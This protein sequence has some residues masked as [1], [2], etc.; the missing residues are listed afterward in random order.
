MRSAPD[1]DPTSSGPRPEEAPERYLRAIID[2]VAD[3]VVTLDAENVIRS[4]NPAALDIFGYSA[5]EIIGRPFQTCL[6]AEDYHGFLLALARCLDQ[7]EDRR[8]AVRQDLAGRRKDGAALA[9]KLSVR[10]M[11]AAGESD[12]VCLVQDVTEKRRAEAALRESEERLKLAVTATRSGIWDA[13]LR[14]GTCWWSPEFIAM[15]G[16]DDDEMPPRIGVWEQ[17]I[18]PE[19]R[20]WTVTLAKRFIEGQTASYR[21]I[22]RLRRKDGSWIWIEAV[23]H[24]VRA[25]DGKAVRFIGAMSDVT[26]RKRHEAELLRLST[27]DPLTG[28]PNR[29]LTLDRLS[30]ALKAARRRGRRAAALYIDLDRFK[31]V[32]DS[33]GHDVGDALLKKLVEALRGALRASDTLG[34]LGGDEFVV[35]AEEL[36]GPQDAARVAENILNVARRPFEAEGRAL[37]TPLSVGIAMDCDPDED[38]AALLRH[39]DTAMQAAKSGG[40]G[41]YR[42]F[43]PEMNAEAVARLEIER[44]L[45]AAVDAGQFIV[46]Y[47]PKFAVNDLALVGAEA[48]VRWRHPVKGMIPPNDF[49]PVAEQTGL[50]AALGAIVLR[51]AMRQ[52][53]EWRRRGLPPLP[54]A[55]NLSVRQLPDE[56]ACLPILAVLEQE[57][58]DPALLELEI[59]ETTMMD[60]IRQIVPA[61]RRLRESGVAVAVD[62]FGTGYSSLAYLRKLPITTLKIDRSFINDVETDAD[63]A[64]IAATIISMGRQLGLQVVAEGIENKGQL[65]FLRR[66]GCDMAQGFFLA[67]PMSADAFERRFANGGSWLGGSP[68]ADA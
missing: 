43:M 32:N 63:S 45:R 54:V 39:A 28:L 58:A 16:Y 68:D 35:V 26:E 37:F 52:T 65:A 49:I 20:A 64:A 11:Q 14:L 12:F 38:A 66:H 60:N 5:D 8:D 24:C 7:P 53:V 23:G 48:L 9:I 44:D 59:T 55:V 30:H 15:L 46:H 56:T 36:D 18:H 13:D 33:L 61:L 29:A 6:A 34:R 1:H 2:H 17:L 10:R 47:Q 3:G 27:R 22:Y 25:A 40:G 62:D 41:T 19:D 4:M 21:P 67:K 50:I 42:F 31:L 57:E 51:E